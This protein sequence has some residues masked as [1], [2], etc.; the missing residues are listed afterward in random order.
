MTTARHLQRR[1]IPPDVLVLGER[2]LRGGIDREQTSRFAD[3][4]WDLSPADHKWHNRRLILNFTALPAQFRQVAKELFFALLAGSPPAGERELAIDTIRG[5]FTRVRVFL[6]WAERRGRATLAALTIED[7]EAYQHYVLTLRGTP[8]W[9]NV[10]RRSVG[11]FGFIGTTYSL[12]GSS[13]TPTGWTNG[14]TRAAISVAVR[15][16]PRG[17][18]SRSSARCWVGRCDGWRS[19]PTTSCAPTTSGLRFTSTTAPTA[20]DGTLELATRGHD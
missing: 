11:C 3:D 1:E 4:R 10:L 7:F 9:R 13:S 6:T 20:P 14:P 18:P 5:H 15:T 16:A 17:S 2:P 12:T 8:G 19:S